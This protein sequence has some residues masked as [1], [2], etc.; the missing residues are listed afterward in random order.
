MCIMFV[1]ASK[2]S[3]ILILLLQRKL[4]DVYCTPTQYRA[5]NKS[6]DTKESHKN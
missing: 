1:A 6:D 5:P 2:S 3:N 4:N